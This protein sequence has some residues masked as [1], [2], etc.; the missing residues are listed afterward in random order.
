MADGDGRRAARGVQML[1]D[2]PT[3][4]IIPMDELER[5]L[6]EAYAETWAEPD[7]AA[8]ALV[9]RPGVA[10]ITQDIVIPEVV[11]RQ[12][13]SRRPFGAPVAAPE[14]AFAPD[15]YAP[16]EYAPEEFDADGFSADEAARPVAEPRRVR[17]GGRHRV[18]APPQALRGRAALLA[19]AAGATV[20][21]FALGAPSS[22]APHSA[23]AEATPT[24]RLSDA[25]A[26]EVPAPTD[27]QQFAQALP[28]GA[29]RKAAQDAAIAATQRPLFVLP[30]KGEF[31]STFG[32][33]WGAMH[34]GVD[35]AGP[36]GTP[37]Y[38]VE[39][40]TIISAG[41]ASGFGLWVRLQAADGTIT[42]Y[43]HVN[44]MTVTVGQHV[45]A[46]DQIATIGNRG[47][48]TGPHLHFEVWRGGTT[49]IDPL[50]WLAQRGIS[51]GNYEG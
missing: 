38:A 24:T 5:R 37:I 23:T 48:S 26:A 20:T 19:L 42:V 12:H 21:G 11:L 34:A 39:D 3:T 32:S 16:E 40:G 44:T 46:G 8:N 50:P 2:E 36:I 27:M 31:T 1:D 28:D 13:E 10:E 41:P 14:E 30:A 17:T 51:L 29:S 47:D 43:G 7:E 4:T 25:S 35:I 15:E 45:M 18:A 49:K 22:K 6:D 33:R 9:Y